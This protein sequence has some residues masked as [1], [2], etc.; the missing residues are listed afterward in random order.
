MLMLKLGE[1]VL[2]GLNRARFEQ[3]LLDTLRR[4]LEGLGAFSVR[5]LQSTVY[6]EPEE[7]VPAERRE[8]VVLRARDAALRVFGI[9]AVTVA[10]KTAPDLSPVLQAALSHCGLQTAQTFKVEARRADKSYPLTSPQICAELGARLLERLPHLTV[11]VHRPEVTVWVEIRE[12]FAYV[13]TAPLP[14]AGGLP[15]GMSGKA[16]LLLSGGIDSPVAGWRMARR[17]LELVAVH[18]HSYP[19]TS[20]ESLEKVR[21]LACR[22]AAWHGPMKLYTVPLT[23]VQERMRAEGPEDYFTL[24]LRRSMAR[25]ASAVALRERCSALITG[26]SLGQVASQT[27]EAMAVTGTASTLPVFRPLAGMDKEEIVTTARQIGT[28]EISIRPFEDCCTVFTPRHPR[29][30]PR[31]GPVLDAEAKGTWIALEGEALTSAQR[32]EVAYAPHC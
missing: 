16:V 1:M 30:R 12:G 21:E 3:R 14:G 7:S 25:I 6:V 4:R 20:R 13:H 29:T 26:E 17:G 19:Y 10:E 11:D 28:F 15:A 27:L 2:K 32:P 31:P 22:L 8:T 5:S 24:L 18:F 9:A 23:A